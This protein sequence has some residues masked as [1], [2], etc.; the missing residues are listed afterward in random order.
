[1][2]PDYH[3]GTLDTAS[4]ATLSGAATATEPASEPRPVFLQSRVWSKAVL[5]GKAARVG[6]HHHL[7]LHARPRGPEG[8]ASPSA[9]T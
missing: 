8:P 5:T 7:R 3:I 6:R 1:M 2:M 4:A 9:S